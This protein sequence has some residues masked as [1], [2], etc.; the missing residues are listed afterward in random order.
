MLKDFQGSSLSL[1]YYVFPLGSAIEVCKGEQGENVH[2]FIF[3]F[4]TVMLPATD[5]FLVL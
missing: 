1:R 4:N 2:L 3:L 5:A